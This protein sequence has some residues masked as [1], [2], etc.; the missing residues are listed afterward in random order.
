M[1]MIKPST[2][3][4]VQE[5]VRTHSRLR[6]QGG[7]SKTALQGAGEEVTRLDLSGLTGVLEY[8][9]EE[10]TFT[11]YSG[12]RIT[13]VAH[14]LATHGQY[15]P[16]DPPLDERGATLGGTVAAGLSGPER[17][18]YGG[19]RDFILGVQFVDGQG[20]LVRSGGRVVK[21]SAGFDL[22]KF[23]VGSLGQYGVLVEVSFKVF[24]RPLAYLTLQ[25]RYANLD[26]ALE[27]LTQLTATPLELFALDLLPEDRG[28]SLLIRLGGAPE[29]L[30]ARA[31][32]LQRYLNGYQAQAQVV[33]LLQGEREGELWRSA[34]QFTWLPQGWLLVKIPLTPR[35]VPLLEQALQGRDALRRYSVA[36]NLA[37]VAWPESAESLDELL[38]P[39]E[40]SGLAVLGQTGRCFLGLRRGDT[41]AR[42]VRQALDPLGKFA[43]FS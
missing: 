7:G 33:D 24:P 1:H 32:R 11:A 12:T 23:M 31:Q 15:L 41:F 14:L 3:S 22:A 16:F 26:Q 35:R 2:I 43:S 42:R 19:I 20:N 36:A 25:A 17:Y 28:A 6:V 9:A 10:F 8:Q 38:K 30:N 34:R 5:I 21:N 18:R 40:F 37:W 4:E 27:A 13:D 39:M 29:T